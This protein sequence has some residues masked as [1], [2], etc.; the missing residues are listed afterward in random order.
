[1]FGISLLPTST[2]IT[3]GFCWTINWSTI[4][5]RWMAMPW[6]ARPEFSIPRILE[7]YHGSKAYQGSNFFVPQFCFIAQPVFQLNDNFN[8]H[9]P[10]SIWHFPDYQPLGRN[11]WLFYR[12]N[13]ISRPEQ[14]TVQ[15]RGSELGPED[16][17]AKRGHR[18]IPPFFFDRVQSPTSFHI[19]GTTSF[20]A[21]KH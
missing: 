2:H 19:D 9:R 8:R 14:R 15:I 21:Q 20:R 5:R 18:N 4:D 16:L 7:L 6:H 10:C 3:T 1:M 13:S 17:L 12:V 11:P